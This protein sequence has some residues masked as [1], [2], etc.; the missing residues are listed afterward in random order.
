MLATRP[1]VDPNLHVE[2]GRK[3]QEGT[4]QMKPGF[5]LRVVTA[6]VLIPPGGRRESG[7]GTELADR[8]R[9]RGRGHRGHARIFFDR[10]APRIPIVQTPGR[11]W[12]PRPS[13][14][15]SGTPRASAS[16]ARLG[17][18]LDRSPRVTVEAVLFG[19]V[20]GVAVIALGSQRSITEVFSSISVSA[21]RCYSSHS[22]SAPWC[23]FMAWIALDRG[24]L[25]FH[26]GHG[27]GR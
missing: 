20:L 15:N 9:F 24:L 5:G 19:F 21:T 7:A 17:D 2:D 3:V 1:D 14:R 8:H 10:R 27:L 6:A 13:S 25:L 22:R 4:D 18:L 12:R 11:T 26:R 16:V 23:A